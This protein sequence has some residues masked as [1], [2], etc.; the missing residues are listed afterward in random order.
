M[1]CVLSFACVLM[2]QPSPSSS[3]PT[4]LHDP[5]LLWCS[6]LVLRLPVACF[7]FSYTIETYTEIH[8]NIALNCL[9]TYCF[10]F[11]LLAFLYFFKISSQMSCI[12]YGPLSLHRAFCTVIQS[13]HQLMLIRNIFYIKTFKIAP[14][15]FHP[16]IIFR[17]LHCSLLK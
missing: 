13:A 14:T 1:A 2:Y 6:H 16:K 9:H 3:I 15:C 8:L 4:L 10:L 11:S 12:K 17:E 5:F 7:P